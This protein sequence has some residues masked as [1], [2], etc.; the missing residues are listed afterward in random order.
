MPCALC[1]YYF[2]DCGFTFNQT[3]RR[4]IGG[5]WAAIVPL[6]IYVGPYIGR[7]VETSLLEVN[8]RLSN[9]HKQWVQLHCKSSLRFILPGQ[10][11][12]H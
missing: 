9:L 6:T 7:L 10:H 5:A 3:H 4:N 8:E 1:L 11:A 12:V 2:A